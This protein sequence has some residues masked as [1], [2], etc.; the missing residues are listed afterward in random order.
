VH[1]LGW[2]NLPQSLVLHMA[3]VDKAR[4]ARLAVPSPS[5]SVCM[6]STVRLYYYYSAASA[7]WQLA[8]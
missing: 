5:A 8:C 4:G 6:D 7:G 2:L 1:P 3:N